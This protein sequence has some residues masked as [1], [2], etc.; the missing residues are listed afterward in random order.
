MT[1]SKEESVDAEL[2]SERQ[3]SREVSFRSEEE[4]GL[5]H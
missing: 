4:E 3:S 5:W 2:K 1:M